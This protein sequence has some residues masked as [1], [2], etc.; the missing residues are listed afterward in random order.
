MG[1]GIAAAG[2]LRPTPKIIVVLTDGFTPWPDTLPKG[3]ETMIVCLTVAESIKTS[4]T[5][6]KTILIEGDE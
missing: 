3:V 4:P 2:Q 5:W 6:A 1:I